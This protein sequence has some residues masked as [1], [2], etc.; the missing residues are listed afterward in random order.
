MMSSVGCTQEVEVTIDP[1]ADT[2]DTRKARG[3]FFTPPEVTEF[4]CGWAITRPDGRVL[5][6]SC[7][8]GAFLA[9]SVQRLRALGGVAPIEAHEL[10][11]GSAH[12]AR[13]LLARMGYPGKV[14]VGDFLTTKPEP[15]FLA[16]VG[17]P[18]YI[19]YQGF[20]GEARA[21]GLAAALAQGVRLTKLSSSW[22]PFVIHSAAF[23]APLGR[24]A[25][26]LPAELL[27]ANYG[28]EVRDFLLRR[29]ARVAVVLIS[30]QVFPGVQTEAVL[31]LAEG[32]GGTRTVRF[33]AVD[34]VDSLGNLTFDTALE[35]GPGERW[36]SALVSLEATDEL[37]ELKVAGQL[38]PLSDWGRISLGGVTGSNRFFTLSPDMA[39]SLGLAASDVVPISPPGSTHLRSLTMTKADHAAL[40][41]AGAKTLLFRPDKPSAAARDY[42]AH[43]EI[44][45][46]PQA[47]KCRVRTPWW[48]TP[49][50]G[51]PTLFF[52][53]MNDHTPQ[54]A[55]NPAAL[56][57]LNSLHGLYVGPE[58]AEVADLLTLAAVNSATA[59]SAEITGRAYGGG[60]LKMEPREAARLLVPSI[61]VVRRH[62]DELT[63]LRPRARRLLRDGRLVEA[64]RLVDD[65]IFPDQVASAERV[66][67]IRSAQAM[68]L[69]RRRQRG[70]ARVR[71][72]SL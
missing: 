11:E 6:P 46:V 34:D 9:A 31:L 19:R 38:S 4:M 53:Y 43:G 27:A 1:A 54:L 41:K 59:L 21:A 17:N 47:Y 5:E 28:Q 39:R 20:T 36:T 68:L 61:D 42:I 18:P 40:G 22:A 32:T 10:H 64:Q 2:A 72:E 66:E 52:T 65:V 44:L 48:R 30:S 25:L 55:T 63:A 56:H 51:P 69:S 23:L 49:L 24:L 50:P 57:Y 7:G 60:I 3:A 71:G 35:V 8:D 62:A 16:V 70:R 67:A 33:A 58:V 12:D 26:V 29:F 14:L 45:G 13:Q 15:S 37:A